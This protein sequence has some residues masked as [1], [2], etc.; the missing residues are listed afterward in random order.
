MDTRSSGSALPR[1]A[2]VAVALAAGCAGTGPAIVQHPRSVVGFEV[3]SPEL[4]PLAGALRWDP[5]VGA[6]HWDPSFFGVRSR[7]TRR[8]SGLALT[9]AAPPPVAPPPARVTLEED[10]WSLALGPDETSSTVSPPV[11]FDA[12]LWMSAGPAP[13]LS[14]VD[15]HLDH[16][17]VVVVSEVAVEEGAW[18][19]ERRHH[20]AP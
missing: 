12:A 13:V 7:E 20:L 4:E 3:V 16:A 9:L 10:A 15:P 18:E 11:A 19:E 8:P 1:F 5:G 17:A 14:R 6:L 2:A